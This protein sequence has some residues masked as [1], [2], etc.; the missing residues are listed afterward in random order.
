MNLDHFHVDHQTPDIPASLLNTF[1][2]VKKKWTRNKE[3]RRKTT[4]KGKERGGRNETLV[5]HV[6][7]YTTST[8]PRSSIP[9]PRPRWRKN[10]R[11]T[12]GGQQYIS[13]KKQAGEKLTK[14]ARPGRNMNDGKK[15]PPFTPL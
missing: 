7:H 2:R 11:E 4:S 12:T 14:K 1:R 15:T 13:D 10:G 8:A 3:A 9:A 6:R 5:P